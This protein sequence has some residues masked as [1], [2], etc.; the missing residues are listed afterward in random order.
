MHEHIDDTEPSRLETQLFRLQ[1]TTHCLMITLRMYEIFS[2]SHSLT[3]ACVQVE[4][5][6]NK[7]KTI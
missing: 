2:F 7:S 5:K 4:K 6:E 3:F 1:H